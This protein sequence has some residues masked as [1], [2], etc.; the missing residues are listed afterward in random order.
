MPPEPRPL[1]TRTVDPSVQERQ[2][3][4]RAYL[5]RRR[6]DPRRIANYLERIMKGRASIEGGTMPIAGVEDFI[7]FTH[8]RHLSYLPG[9]GRLRRDYRIEWC[10]GLIDN[11]WV[12]CPA[13]IV[14]RRS[15]ATAT[16]DSERVA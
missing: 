8:V 6:I 10:D 12:R 11:D 2:Q 9:A 4:L 16:G 7:A 15:L 13:F 5:D 3:A 14:H 1:H